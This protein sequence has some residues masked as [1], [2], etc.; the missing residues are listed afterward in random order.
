MLPKAS[1][2]TREI[3]QAQAEPVTP[4]RKVDR[5]TA[6]EISTMLRAG[7]VPQGTAPL[8]DDLQRRKPVAQEGEPD[9]DAGGVTVDMG[10][11]REVRDQ[12]RDS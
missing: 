6:L 4:G 10:A 1:V 5:Q 7:A 3:R 9:D 8:V 2:G 12:P 11:A